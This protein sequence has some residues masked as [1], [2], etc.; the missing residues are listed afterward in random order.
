VY[1]CYRRSRTR[2]QDLRRRSWP[3]YPSIRG[4]TGTLYWEGLNGEV[5]NESDLAASTWKRFVFFNGK[6]VARIDSST[7]NVYYFYSDHLG[8]IGVVTDALGDTIENESDYYPYGGEIVIT[9]SL[10]D[11]HYKFTGKEFDSESSFNY[12]GSRH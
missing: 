7:G 6:V 3:D 9:S 8:S 12:F 4:A 11:E 2:T 1:D 5:L 10:S